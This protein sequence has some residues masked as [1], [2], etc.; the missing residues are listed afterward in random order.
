[1]QAFQT[2][3]T[4]RLSRQLFFRL[5]CSVSLFALLVPGLTSLPAAA[6]RPT[7]I[8]A[9]PQV[10][11]ETEVVPNEVLVGVRAEQDTPAEVAAL[12][13]AFGQTTGR[14]ASLH[15]YRIQLRNGVSIP[16]AVA[17]LQKRG[18]ILYAEPN[19]IY[20]VQAAPNNPFYA[21][22]QY[23][24]QK[25]QADLAWG[26]WQPHTPIILAIVDT[27][28][29][30]T[31][32][33]LT[34]KILRDASGI[35]GYSAFVG[36]R[37][38]AKDDHGHGT[39]C[40]GIAASQINNGV[41]VA[42]ISGW[43]GQAG[44]TDT[45][46]TKLMPV[47]VLD[48][49]GSGT[50]ATVADGITWAANNGA[51][52]ISM[53]LGG[54]GS[55]TLANAVQYAWSKGCVI[56]AAAGNSATSNFS[57][58]GAYP[59][60]IS[61]AA[62]DSSDKLASFSNYGSWVT[63]A[64]PG[65]NI[66]STLPTYA[67]T[68]GF[69]Q[70]YGYLSGTSMAT[71]LVAGEAALMLAQNSALT[72]AQVSNLIKSNVDSYTAYYNGG[73]IA[74]GSGRVNVYR[75]LQAAGG[76][77]PTIPSAPSYLTASPANA[78]V[79]LNW[80]VV[81]GALTYTVKRGTVSGG[82]YTSLPAVVTT[83]S[84]SDTGLTN[85]TTYYYVVS[86]VNAVGESTNSNEAAATPVN[87]TILYQINS[88]GSAVAPFAADSNSNGGSSYT[89]SNPVDTLGVV[90]AAPASVYQTCR[91]GDF[92]YIF[93]SL[94]PGATYTV[95]LH[96]AETYFT[97]SGQRVFNLIINGTTVQSGFDIL[98]AAGGPNK[99]VVRQY[100]ATADSAG[101]V[102][103]STQSTVTFALISGV[104]LL[105][106][107]S[108]GPPSAPAG[109]TATAGNTSASLSWTSVSGA[110][111]Y[112]VY[113]STV[114]GG[115]YTA[116]P[117]TV[118]TNS[119]SDTGLTNGTTY[120]YV[121]T[122]NNASG[123]SAYSNQASATPSA[124]TTLFQINAGGNASGTFSADNYFA[125]G[126]AYS[127]GATVD[128]TGVANAAPASVYQTCRYGD[129][130][131]TLPNLTPGA[132]YTVRL[133]F[134]ETYFTSSGQRVCNVVI[135]GTTVQSNLD[136]FAA[137]GGTNKALAEQFTVTA[138]SAGKVSIHLV[139]VVSLPLLSG[140]EVIH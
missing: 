115:S 67:A 42:G 66:Y 53:S 56:V 52:V 29:D 130:T 44:V 41:G 64:A 46:Y 77:V 79:N 86:A 121:V 111:G 5:F 128:T 15:A 31:H 99:A 17:Q 65:V 102:S 27:G 71:P 118:T 126:S 24:P 91:Y 36:A 107:A 54:G 47:K 75:A 114:N 135:N 98:A 94:T 22:N 55:V 35:V 116:L 80:S 122:A 90:N 19:H 100:T 103:V 61:V 78:S 93:S 18:E 133:H 7:Q 26:I 9:P 72:N 136:V 104:E 129:F 85:G 112:K 20:R 4:T 13:A 74:A 49:N 110:T 1:M 84:Y 138:D 58:P 28:I 106:I 109:V 40:A 39:H 14:Q 63:V 70:N 89:G 2:R 12:D 123:E 51:R 59:N 95:R 23:A 30:N 83:N 131:Y 88:G 57:Y 8:I 127:V 113:R 134:A 37:N 34:N 33:G 11:L 60:V 124:Q 69:G 140:I 6:Q 48:N 45:T 3:R 137:A 32:P 108:A 21:S 117:G 38:D 62:T 105:S 87:Q 76:I 10:P 50:D 119:Y 97:T 120:Y 68:A 96:F 81:P 43:S 82:P 73:G 139:S 132:T 25:V 125:G 101:K 16:A 92:A